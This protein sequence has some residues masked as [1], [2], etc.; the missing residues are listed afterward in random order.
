M[1]ANR[2]GHIDF[3]DFLSWYTRY[4]AS[5][6]E[7]SAAASIFRLLRRY[8]IRQADASALKAFHR[9]SSLVSLLA[10]WC[11][12]TRECVRAPTFIFVFLRV[13]ATPNPTSNFIS[14][15]PP[16]THHSNA[17]THACTRRAPTCT[18]LSAH[19][20][21]HAADDKRAQPAPS[22]TP[23]P[24]HIPAIARALTLARTRSRRHAATHTTARAP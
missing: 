20:M 14:Q 19:H 6:E 10:L 11:I 16:Q 8:H 18:P 15:R 24:A 4:T 1:D 23:L 17:H 2:D 7:D 13:Y 9:I 5:P 12:W 3:D 22:P 21:A